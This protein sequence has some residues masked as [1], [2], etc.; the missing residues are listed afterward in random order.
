MI[1]FQEMSKKWGRESEVNLEGA[2]CATDPGS[3]NEST[4]PEASQR[5]VDELEEKVV[6]ITARL[7]EAEGKAMEKQIRNAE[8]EQEI[9]RMKKSLETMDILKAQVFV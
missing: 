5:S 7:S 9:A 6:V 4:K 1:E 2:L 3:V 8:L